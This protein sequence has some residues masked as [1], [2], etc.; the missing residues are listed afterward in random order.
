M[1]IPHELLLVFIHSPGA[2]SQVIG[3]A[4]ILFV[5]FKRKDYSRKAIEVGGG[6]RVGVREG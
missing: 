5:C 6:G 1:V 4:S 3:A 2:C